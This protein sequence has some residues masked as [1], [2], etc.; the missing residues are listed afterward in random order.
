M[1]T[2]TSI[3]A[4]A[5]GGTA[6]IGT[7]SVVTYYAVNGTD[8]AKNVNEPAFDNQGQNQTQQTQISDARD[9]GQLDAGTQD[10]S[11]SEQQTKSNVGTAQTQSGNSEAQE[12][13]DN[14]VVLSPGS[15]VGEEGAATS[16]LTVSN[17]VASHSDTLSSAETSGGAVG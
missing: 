2:P 3:A 14:A 1:P 16:S 9:S 7:A 17:P 15:G 10:R 6:V 8:K 4:G 13:T 11:D 5:V 12:R